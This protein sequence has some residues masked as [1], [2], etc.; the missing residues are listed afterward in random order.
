MVNRDIVASPTQVGLDADS[1]MPES[2]LEFIECVERL[3][4]FE[5]EV[6]DKT[7][8]SQQRGVARSL[9]SQGERE[10]LTPCDILTRGSKTSSMKPS[11]SMQAQFSV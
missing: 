8:T 11:P 4:V 6:S 1:G 9:R 2:N 5:I 10:F 3:V 7:L